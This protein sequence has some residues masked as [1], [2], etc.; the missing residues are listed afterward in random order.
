MCL[1]FVGQLL[2]GIFMVIALGLTTLSIFL[3]GLKE[4]QEATADI[5]EDLKHFRIPKEFGSLELL[6]RIAS[7]DSVSYNNET[8]DSCKYWFHKLEDWEKIVV[9]LMCL[10]LIAEIITIS[11]TIISFFGCYCRKICMQ[12]LLVL[13]LI[14]ASFLAAAV[15][16]FA[17]NNQKV[18]H[19]INF[20]NLTRSFEIKTQN[21]AERRFYFACFALALAIIDV[22]IGCLNICFLKFCC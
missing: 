15:T 22:F 9:I 19:N 20:A 16:V 2:F 18:V 8:N 17:I 21:E 11:W 3:P 13:S 5:S 10:S 6:C 4:L 12:L 7:A 14:V 1:S